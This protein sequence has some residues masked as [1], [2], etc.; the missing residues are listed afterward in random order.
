VATSP[1]AYLPDGGRPPT[2]RPIVGV[3]GF[4]GWGN[5]GDE[6]FW[7]T[8]RQH[9]APAMELRNLMGPGMKAKGA[10]LQRAVRGVDA[11]LIGGGDLVIPWRS[12]RYW[13]RALLQ[14]PVFIAGVGVP[15]WRSANDTGV[16]RLR[17]FFRHPAVQLVAA[18][19]E[20]SARW[21]ADQLDPRLDVEQ[22]PDLVCGL[23]LPPVPPPAGP[24]IL[25]VN[26]R[27]RAG[28]LDDL[29]RV[30]ELCE[31]AAARGWR[32]RR[33]VL[34][35]GGVR[36]QDLVATRRL[37]L[38]DSELVATDDLGAISRAIGEC[39]AFATMK[40][41][42]VVVAAMSGVTPIALMPT[43]KTRR[44][45]AELGRAELLSSY[46]DPG[47]PAMVEKELPPIAPER[48]DR[49]RHDAAAF[50]DRLRSAILAQAA[51]GWR[52]G[53]SSSAERR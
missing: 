4:Y 8:F 3:V 38:D 34:G 32:I 13:N 41:H 35:T 45:L 51:A 15:E 11:V 27:H 39:R 47:L 10:L 52:P 42:G 48:R 18:R 1:S 37:G 28:G 25:G 12:S 23:T 29:T 43:T 53:R 17:R 26:V 6:L 9:L 16:A 2:D 46:L 49:M 31:R 24:P 5:Y 33:I 36:E 21:I 14:R 7:E 50:L 40:F 44:F 20:G 30:R 22:S 19:D